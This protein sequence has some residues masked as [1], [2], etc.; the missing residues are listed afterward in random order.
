MSK[1]TTV[2]L[3]IRKYPPFA[4][5]GV[6]LSLCLSLFAATPAFSS[7]SANVKTIE[8]TQQQK[9]AIKG[10]VKDTHGNSINHHRGTDNGFTMVYVIE[11]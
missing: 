1:S 8:S 4:M 11:V 5:G 10:V 7:T 2:F 9:Q 3:G 6:A